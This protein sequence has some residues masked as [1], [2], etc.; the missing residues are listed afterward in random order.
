MEN[1]QLNDPK[2]VNHLTAIVSVFNIVVAVYLFSFNGTPTADDEQFFAS[3]ARNLALFGRLSVEQLYGNLRIKG[4]YHGVEPGYSVLASIWYHLFLTTNF[5]HLQSLYLLPI[6]YTGLSA[7]L[8][9]LISFQLNFSIHTGIIAGFLYGLSTMAWPYAKTLFREPLIT[10]LILSSFAVFLFL[11]T[12]KHSIWLSIS[13][14]ILLILL[15]V[16]LILTKVSMGITGIALFITLLFINS[17]IKAAKHRHVIITLLVLTFLLALLSLVGT[18]HATDANIYYRF[19]GTFIHDVIGI[20]TSQ[21]HAH[22]VEALIAPLISPWK[23]LFFYSPI[24]L[25]GLIASVKFIRSRPELF[26]LPM[27]VLVTLLFN[28]A[29]AYDEQWWTPTWGSRFLVPAIPLMI[30]S[31]LPILQNL[32]DK[33]KK[34]HIVIASLFILGFAIQL[35]AIFFNSSEYAAL[36]LPNQSGFVPFWYIWNFLNSP[37]INQW[38][39]LNSQQ[40][41]DFLLGRTMNVQS[42]LTGAI[43]FICLILVAASATWIYGNFKRLSNS[44]KWTPIYFIGSFSLILISITLLLV[45]G[46]SDPNYHTSQFQPLC[47]YIHNNVMPGDIIVLQPYPGPLWDDLANNECGQGIW[48]SLPYNTDIASNAVA[49]QLINHLTTRVLPAKPSYWLIEQVWSDSTPLNAQLITTVEHYKL[50]KEKYLT[51]PYKIFVG[52]YVKE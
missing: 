32:L 38:K 31:T 21:S 44:E 15:L 37:I 20:L 50:I 23:G 45:L 40:Q 11:T 29:L 52:Y 10:L 1:I 26:I 36:T 43:V 16:F 48:Y 39:L 12:K 6:L 42:L 49:I 35:P 2:R 34:G 3:A 46:E 24:C 9:T 8:V 41:A 17:D 13:L 47:N 19:S 14:F 33:G 30:L 28:Q 18:I 5:G 22:L 7:V 4:Y 27:L 51:I 25:V